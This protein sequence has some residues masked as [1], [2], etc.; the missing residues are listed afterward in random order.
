MKDLRHTFAS[1][2]MMKG[3][4]ILSLQKILGHEDLQTTLIYAH[5]SPGYL[6][7]EIDRLNFS[8]TG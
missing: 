3:R 6:E 8:L 7:G 4:N 5:L 1:N 2:F